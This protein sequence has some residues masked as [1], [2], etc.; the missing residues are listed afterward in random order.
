MTHVARMLVDLTATKTPH[1]LANVIYEAAYRK[2]FDR[3]ATRAA[4]ARARGRHGVAVLERALELNAA[5]SAG[6]KSD[7]EDAFL[8]LLG[9]VGFAEPLVN[10]HVEGE[11]AD[12]CWPDRRLIA[13]VDGPGHLR[14][15]AKRNDARKEA[16][17]RAAGYEVLRFTDNVIERQ[18]DH[19]VHVLS[20]SF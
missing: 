10:T 7:L 2:R 8:A 13:E 12:C 4:I 5:G 19:V 6:T 20:A 15:R 3:R 16:I 11:E 14:P 17:W 1:Q 18:P 9:S